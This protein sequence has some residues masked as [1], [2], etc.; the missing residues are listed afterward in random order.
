MPM[1]YPIKPSFR[2]PTS[3]KKSSLKVS[4]L[5]TIGFTI[6]ELM[7]TI[8]IA[9]ILTAV[10]MPKFN[11][12]MINAR[13]DNE[14]SELHRLLL[15]AR[16]TA[17][18]TG[19][20]VTVCPLNTSKTCS[21]NWQGEISVFTNTASNTAYDAVNETL[22][23][24]KGSIKAGDLLQYS[25]SSI[26]Y[27]PAGRLTNNSS[28]TFSYCPKNN[29]SMSRGIDVTISGRVYSTSDTDNDGKDETRNG[30][31]ITCS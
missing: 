30:S 31:E 17:I 24:V 6:I 22:V 7:V 21:A 14:I 25:Q 3:T 13:V 27:T 10:A 1:R 8:A 12:L 29:A 5:T 28:D 19:Q 16:N 2:T 4:H 20:N 15:T 26:I 11:D 18:N 23:K 9:G